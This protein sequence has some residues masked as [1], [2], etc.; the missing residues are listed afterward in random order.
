MRPQRVARARKK[1]L[2][3]QL[4][5]AQVADVSVRGPRTRRSTYKP[6]YVYHT[7]EDDVR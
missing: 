1:L 5:A 6:D 2:Q 3:R 7:G 4:A